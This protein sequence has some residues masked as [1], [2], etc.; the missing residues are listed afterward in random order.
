MENTVY[1]DIDLPTEYRSDMYLVSKT[2]RQS[3][4]R[5]RVR[6]LISDVLSEFR[7]PG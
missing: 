4:V 6:D 7:E 2:G 5:D 3:I 1:R